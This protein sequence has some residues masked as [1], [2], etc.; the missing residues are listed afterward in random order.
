MARGILDELNRGSAE[1][2]T[3]LSQLKA[4]YEKQL[5]EQQHKIDLE[6]QKKLAEDDFN[7]RKSQIEFETKLRA[8][9]LKQNSEEYKK[10]LK[11]H[12]AE[13]DKNE[14]LQRLKLENDIAAEQKRLMEENLQIE[15]D[16]RTRILDDASASFSDKLNAAVGEIFSKDKLS[17]SISDGVSSTLNQL[18]SIIDKYVS[19]QKGV[20]ARL[21]GSG[22]TFSSAEALL[23]TAVGVQP[24]I[25]TESMINKLSDLVD[26]GVA[27]NLEMRAFLGTV[28][29]NIAT[30]F[31]IANAS[32]LRIVRLQ[33]SDSSAARLGIEASLTR[34]LNEMFQNTEYL[35]DEYDTVQGAL[36]EASS[37]MNSDEAIQFEY[38][39]QKWLGSLYSVGM[40]DNTVSGLATALGYLG[41]GNVSAL[42]NSEYQSLLV[43]AASR[44]GLNYSDML[45]NGLNSATTNTLLNSMTEYLKEI[46]SGTNQVVKS[47]L[48]STFGVSVSDLTAALNLNSLELSAISTKSMN[49]VGALGELAYQ[50]Q[51][52]PSRINSSEQ[53]DTLWQNSLWSLGSGVAES[54]ILS[55]IWKVTSLIQDT[56]GGINI[57]MTLAMGTGFDLNTTVDNLIKLGVVG[58]GSLG[59]IGDIV[60]G[61]SSTAD[62]SSML[63]KLAKSSALANISSIGGRGLS[64]ATSG[65]STSSTVYAGNSSGSDIAAAATQTATDSAQA[66]VDSKSSEKN[67]TDITEKIQID[68]ASIV[69]TLDVLKNLVGANG[70]RVET[71]GG[72]SPT[73]ESAGI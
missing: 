37:M 8:S 4:K 62:P 36:L 6:N 72:G 73:T 54:P 38:Q 44:A 65:L 58:T 60:S 7:R 46:A 15:K 40:S 9:G 12:Q 61:L 24:Y 64:V 17:K 14:R 52:L 70:L 53:I 1:E 34:Y 20:N 19:F 31:D 67:I 16:A 33:Q 51:A 30:T 43:M 5:R 13:L 22:R 25:K 56:T 68:V 18:D 45:V 21:Q 32:L 29:E 59:M 48:A 28:S 2:L 55:A 69:D 23:S 10:Q 11:K 35:S 26:T 57:P 39:V 66:D 50:L 3:S 47:E 41:S 71:T 63:A 27:Y 42:S 49:T